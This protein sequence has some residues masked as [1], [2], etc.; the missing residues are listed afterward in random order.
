MYKRNIEI[1]DHIC[2]LG[3]GI[4]LFFFEYVFTSFAQKIGHGSD[5][6]IL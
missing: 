6:F 1:L 2:P 3:L 4:L 5:T